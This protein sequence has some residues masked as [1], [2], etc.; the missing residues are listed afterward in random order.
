MPREELASS[1]RTAAE[2]QAAQQPQVDPGA[3]C[4]ATKIISEFF[5]APLVGDR[6]RIRLV[7]NK[8]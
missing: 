4:L 5:A 7:I 8:E 1:Y 2:Q 3:R 6:S